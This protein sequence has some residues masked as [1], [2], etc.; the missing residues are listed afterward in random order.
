[1]HICLYNALVQEQLVA[2]NFIGAH[3]G[4]PGVMHEKRIKY[5]R[6][7]LQKEILPCQ[8]Q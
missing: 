6:E 1:M 3:D 2:L 4:K 8:H 7:I 5:A